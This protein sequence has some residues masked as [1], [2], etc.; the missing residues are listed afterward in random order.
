VADP[1]ECRQGILILAVSA[2]W[3]LLLVGCPGSGPAPA[4]TP[5]T[6]TVPGGSCTGTVK[7][8]SVS[9]T[10]SPDGSTL[11]VKACI[12]CNGAPLA[13]IAGIKATLQADD[14]AKFGTIVTR[15]GQ[16]TFPAT[17]PAGCTTSNVNLKLGGGKVPDPIGQQVEVRV[18]D[19]SGSV[20]DKTTVTV[21]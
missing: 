9:A 3:S 7:I 14:L 11:T 17:D 1:R 15:L 8:T 2:V 13:G 16:A 4:P 18:L 20:V 21:Q 12:T 6:V 10:V 19:S 5:V